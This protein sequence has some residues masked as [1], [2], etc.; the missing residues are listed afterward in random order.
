MTY[1]SF[2][3]HT[4]KKDMTATVSLTTIIKQ[5]QQD[6]A[7][8]TVRNMRPNLVVKEHARVDD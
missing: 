7:T 4:F 1:D 2:G 6:H 5:I 3:V 8:K